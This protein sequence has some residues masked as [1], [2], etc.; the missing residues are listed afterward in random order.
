MLFYGCSVNGNTG[1]SKFWF[2][3]THPGLSPNIY[4]GEEVDSTEYHMKFIYKDSRFLSS[5]ILALAAC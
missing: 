3:P 4:T 2:A 5:D 1:T